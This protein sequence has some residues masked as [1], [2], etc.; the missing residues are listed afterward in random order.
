MI[1][2]G[3]PKEALEDPFRPPDVAC[4]VRCLHCGQEYS[5]DTI[6]WRIEGGQGFWCCPID[7]CGGRGYQFDMH[8]LDSLLW[9]DDEDDDEDDDFADECDPDGESD[10]GDDIPW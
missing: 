4:Q 3:L 7:G 2:W 6:V 9:S 8:P 1:M 10:S 5:S